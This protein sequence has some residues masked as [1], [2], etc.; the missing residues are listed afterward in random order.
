[1]TTRPCWKRRPTGSI[2]QRRKVAPQSLVCVTAYAPE[3]DTSD[4]TSIGQSP[5]P[6]RWSCP[7]GTN[8]EVSSNMGNKGVKQHK[9]AKANT[10]K[11]NEKEQK[12]IQAIF[13]K[14]C[15]RRSSTHTPAANEERE[16]DEEKL[17]ASRS[18]PLTL[19]RWNELLYFVLCT[20]VSGV[21]VLR[22]FPVHL[23]ANRAGVN[24]KSNWNWS[25][26][27]YGKWYRCGLCTWF[28]V[29]CTFKKSNKTLSA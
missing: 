26:P 28:G 1:M 10:A 27:W 18:A 22:G 24:S 6:F 25:F 20:Y 4:L 15:G 13:D 14:L 3:G 11:F 5:T 21:I 16:F 19:R 8:P 23:I 2:I 17:K 9:G 7:V 12:Q 29:Q